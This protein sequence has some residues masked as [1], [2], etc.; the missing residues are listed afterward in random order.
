MSPFFST[1]KRFQ[2]MNFPINLELN[3]RLIEVQKHLSEFGVST[4]KAQL[5]KAAIE[6]GRIICDDMEPRELERKIKR[7]VAAMPPD[8]GVMTNISGLEKPAMP[9]PDGINSNVHLYNCYA[10]IGLY[11]SFTGRLDV[12]SYQIEAI[13]KLLEQ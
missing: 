8:A 4:T 7:A 9:L 10:W 1:I 5:L 12:V 6:E 11:Q 2:K 3:Q 13:K